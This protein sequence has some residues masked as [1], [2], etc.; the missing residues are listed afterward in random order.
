MN[1][2]KAVVEKPFRIIKFPLNVRISGPS[3]PIF[4]PEENLKKIVSVNIIKPQIRF[5]QKCV[6]CCTPSN[7]SHDATIRKGKNFKIG[8]DN[9]LGEVWGEFKETYSVPFCQEHLNT[10]RQKSLLNT[11]GFVTGFI[12]FALLGYLFNPWN[13][14]EDLAGLVFTSIVGGIGSVLIASVFYKF[15]GRVSERFKAL[16]YWPWFTLDVDLDE[17]FLSFRFY[18]KNFENE[19]IEIN[20]EWKPVFE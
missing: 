4:N 11:I 8:S 16:G 6:Y 14:I 7:L 17:E 2:N 13:P 19:F 3:I 5:P 1:D 12:L 15:L 9:R 20:Q 18:N 10:L